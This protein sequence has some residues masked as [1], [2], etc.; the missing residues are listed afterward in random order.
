MTSALF[1]CDGG[2]IP[3]SFRSHQWDRA[4]QI[5]YR[6]QT[7]NLSLRLD[8]LS[9][10]LLQLLD[11][12]A[13]DLVRVAAYVYAA[14][15]FISR[16]G[17]TDIYGQGWS[18]HFG[19]VIPVN[20]PDLWNAPAV[21]SALTETLY[22]LSDDR[23]EFAFASASQ[24]DPQQF[25]LSLD[26]E[27]ILQLL[28]APDSVVLF[29]GGTD[30]LCATLK[31][32]LGEGKRPVLVSHRSSPRIHGRQLVLV[33][34]LRKRV[35]AWNF[36]H[37]GI[38]I[39]RIGFDHGET[40]QRTR[41]FL[42]TS[43][44]VAVASQ[45][46]ISPVVLADNGITTI[47]PPINAQLVGALATRST[48]PKFID[49]FN[50][51]VGS[52]FP[53]RSP[54]TSNPFLFLTRP[55]VLGLL[56]TYSMAELLQATNSCAHSRNR[57]LISPHCG[58]CSQC[59]ERRFASIAC[60]LEEHDLI[61]Q[62]GRDIFLH[63]LPEGTARTMALSYIRFA[64]DIQ[65][66]PN[67]MQ[68]YPQL[69]DC[70][71]PSDPNPG[72]TA[73]QIVSM[74]NRHAATIVRIADEQVASHNLVTE[75]LPEACLVRL[76][77]GGQHLDRTPSSSD[78]AAKPVAIKVFFSYAHEDD[79]LRQELSNHLSALRREGVIAEWYDRE[80]IAGHELTQEIIQQLQTADMILLLVSSDF[81]AS[82][83]CW[84]EEVTRAIAR[85]DAGNCRVIPIILRPVD[86]LSTS[87][88]KLMALPKDGKPITDRNYWGSH[89]EALVDV[90]RGVRMAVDELRSNPPSV[91]GI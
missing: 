3:I 44:A 29:S 33:R 63:D 72:Q 54:V 17:P 25:P 35:A 5:T 24:E 49:Y 67:V 82:N 27:A 88:G 18:R 16:G 91:T 7:P 64:L 61:D 50:R 89:D 78:R 28:G 46:G 58:V 69:Y 8:N 34:E 39:N 76:I 57:P 6:G 68:S 85:H 2:E 22:F 83:F 30:S 52:L 14:D 40:T 86:W 66:D 59:V 9:H 74:L 13:T 80:I 47:Q 73:E 87:L 41:S 21:R 1:Q 10:N 36:P 15:Q 26:P 19:M 37:I 90:A 4:E 45:L 60:G 48:H 71:L 42:Y 53:V 12:T 51:L 77:G 79:V 70:I 75:Q 43:I 23:W 55:E 31:M 32:C 62:Y 65:K 84:H 38:R 20:D 56:T 11:S 81:L